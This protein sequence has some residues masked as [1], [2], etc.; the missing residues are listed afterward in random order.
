MNNNNNYLYKY[1]KYKE[2]YKAMKQR[3]GDPQIIDDNIKPDFT[4]N[5]LYDELYHKLKEKM[6]ET[7]INDFDLKNTRLQNQLQ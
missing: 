7:L 3:G 4:K 5:E 6:S 1:K 2:K